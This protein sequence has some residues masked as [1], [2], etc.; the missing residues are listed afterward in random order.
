[1]TDQQVEVLD[2][3]VIVRRRLGHERTSED[4]APSARH[5]AQPLAIYGVATSVLGQTTITL[6]LRTGR[7]RQRVM[8]QPSLASAIWQGAAAGFQ[9]ADAAPDTTPETFLTRVPNSPQS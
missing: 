1:M 4:Q 5:L 6:L 2:T 7:Q 8:E 3:A 9:E